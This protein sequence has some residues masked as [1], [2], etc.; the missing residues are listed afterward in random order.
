MKHVMTLW[1]S[2]TDWVSQHPKDVAAI[3]VLA[4]IAAILAYVLGPTLLGGLRAIAQA[5][6]HLLRSM[7]GIFHAYRVS[8]QSRKT[9]T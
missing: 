1:Y 2:F 9:L 3:T 7:P 8:C 6:R 5:G 4:G